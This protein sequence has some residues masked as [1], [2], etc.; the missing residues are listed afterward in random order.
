[1]IS[2]VNLHLRLRQYLPPPHR[3]E[4][5]LQTLFPFVTQQAIYCCGLTQCVFG[6]GMFSDRRRMSSTLT[7][8]SRGDILTGLV[9]E[10]T[11]EKK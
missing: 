8:Y 11:L 1:M 5:R 9:V 4:Q 6:T 10:T 2:F 7:S 3:G